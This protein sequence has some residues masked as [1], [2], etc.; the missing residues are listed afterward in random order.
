MRPITISYLAPV[1]M[2]VASNVFMT[3]AWYGHLNYKNKP[4]WAVVFV[5]WGIALFEYWLA[6][7][8]IRPPS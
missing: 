4:L 5:S 8:S 3:F 1:V 6:A 2:L 7:R